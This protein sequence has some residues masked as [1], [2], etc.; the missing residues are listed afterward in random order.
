MRFLEQH[1][2]DFYPPKYLYVF[3]MQEQVLI[4]NFQLSLFKT[5]HHVVLLHSMDMAIY[6]INEFI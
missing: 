6:H 5:E 1:Q 2:Q 3:M 4:I